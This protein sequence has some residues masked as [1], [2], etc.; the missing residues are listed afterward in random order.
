MTVAVR[1]YTRSGN[2]KKLADAV[3]SAVSVESKDI[4]CPLNEKVDVLFLGCSY[5][6]FDVDEAVKKFI[7]ENKDNIGKIVCIGT[8]AMMKSMKKPVKKVAD[9]VGIT[10]ADEEF[11]CRGEFAKIHKGRPNEKDLAD[12]SAFAKSVMD[13]EG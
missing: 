4:S 6:A 3:A 13:Q 1:Y 10:V 9:T 7:I 2:T 5:Y 8:S 12:V 11:H